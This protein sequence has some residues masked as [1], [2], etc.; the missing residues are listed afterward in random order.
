[1]ETESTAKVA[2]VMAVYNGAQYLDDQI[3]SILGQTYDNWQL[4]ISDDCSNDNSLQ[5]VRKYVQSEPR[6]HLVLEDKHFGNAQDHFMALLREVAGE[7]DYYMFCDQDDVWDS[8]KVQLEVEAADR[9]PKDRPVLVAT[10]LRVVREDLSVIS[11]SF[12][13]YG[14]LSPVTARFGN[15]LIENFVTG[16]TVLI[17]NSLASLAA[18]TPAGTYMVMHDWWLALIAK[19]LGQLVYLPTAT[20]SY[21]QHGDNSL[22][23]AQYGIK[24]I[25]ASWDWAEQCRNMHN[26]IRQADAFLGQYG[27]QL[28]DERRSE[29]IS[30]L[31]FTTHPRILRVVKLAH[32]HAWKTGM[33][34]C[35]GETIGVL[36]SRHIE[37]DW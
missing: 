11:D 36:F 35:L 13:N 3:Q 10:D 24:S 8:N 33:P 9:Q 29:A 34:R 16:C 19:G 4:F 31:G 18:D 6:I 27:S 2:I 37:K 32:A 30:F 28:D 17:N 14:N 15:L 26:S 5:T 20:I 23:A 12:A 25:L 1:M 21:R 7:F 22:G